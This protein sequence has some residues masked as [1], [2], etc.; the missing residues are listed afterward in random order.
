MTKQAIYTSSFKISAKALHRY[1]SPMEI[2][3]PA[4]YEEVLKPFK[5]REIDF[6]KRLREIDKKDD[7]K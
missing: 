5:E 4:I 6:C 1:K 3:I 2:M 7:Q